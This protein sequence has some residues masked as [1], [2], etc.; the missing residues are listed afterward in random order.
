MRDFFRRG[1]VRFP[2]DPAV[3]RWAA[4]AAP[5][6]RQ[7][8]DDPDHRAD[9]LRCGGTWFA[10][11]NVFPN[12]PDGSVPDA[13]IPPLAGA[14][15]DFI[16]RKLGLS[17]FD[18]DPAQIS[19]CLPGYPR[20]WEGETDAAYRFRRDRDA[21]H[22]DG[23][24]RDENRRRRPGERHG[25]I[26]GL[27]L[28]ATPPEAAPFVVYEG[29]HELMR[30]TLTDR[31]AGIPPARWAGEDVTDAYIQ[32]R[33]KA[34]DTCKRVEI[35]ARP[36]EAYI[37]HRLCLHGVAPWRGSFEGMRMIAYFRPDPYP[38]VPP[39]WWLQHP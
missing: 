27:P 6:A 11:V 35:A 25:F 23:L 4:A 14:P 16:T 2:W 19:I 13:G 8:F 17:G 22:L 20:P 1:W 12:G 15:V 31:L 7:T 5:V 28:S 21:A 29:S 39:E 26:L 10:G 34:F 18:W 36:G 30:Q 37:A 24:L 32:A 9:W 3:A 38:G 33:R